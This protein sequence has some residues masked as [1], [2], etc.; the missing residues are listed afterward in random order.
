MIHHAVR[1]LAR[2]RT[3]T[4]AA[5]ATLAIGIGGTAGVFTLVDGVLLRPLPYANADRL[6]DLSHT[7]VVSGILHVDQSDATYLLYAR[8]NHVFTDIGA[9][10]ATAVNVGGLA[11]SNASDGERATRVDA[12]LATASVF[13]VLRS[14]PAIGRGMTEQ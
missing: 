7:L 2:A 8:D 5:I 12:A 13:R 4:L 3:F 14:T 9:Y 10:R 1:R 11:G 6:V